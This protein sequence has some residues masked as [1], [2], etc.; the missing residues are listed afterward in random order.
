MGSAS[1]ALA[2]VGNGRFDA[3]LQETSLSAWDIVA[4]GLI[5]A[6]ASIARINAHG[7]TEASLEPHVN[8]GQVSGLSVRSVDVV[9][10]NSTRG[11]AHAFVSSLRSSK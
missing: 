9:A 3:F 7:S 1:L 5:A 8:V 11:E 4:A 6:G 2:Y 10:D